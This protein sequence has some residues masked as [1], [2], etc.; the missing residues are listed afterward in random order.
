MILLGI[1]GPIGHG[2][3]TLANFLTEIDSKAQQTESS[4]VISEVANELNTFFAKEQ[5]KETDLDSVN[6]WLSHLPSILGH[7]TQVRVPLEKVTLKQQNIN[8]QPADYEKLFQYIAHVNQQP[9]LAHEVITS[10]NKQHYRALLQ[11]LGG[12]FVTHVS[13]GIWYDELVRRAQNAARNGCPLFIIGGVRFPSDGQII[14]SAGGHVLQIT[15]PGAQVLDQ[16]DPTERERAKVV[17][18]SQ[19]TNNA[20]LAELREAAHKIYAD[21]QRNQLGKS[22]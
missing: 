15:R 9:S 20:T 14:Q 22:Y 19:I 16:A 5:P 11:W 1:T 6:R 4:L 10:H 12:Y 7:I 8:K 2:K 18:D 17:F 13:R 3:T 21:L